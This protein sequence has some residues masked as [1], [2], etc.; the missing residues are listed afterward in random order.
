M[1]AMADPSAVGN[2]LALEIDKLGILAMLSPKA[3]CNNSFDTKERKK[4]MV[5]DRRPW[6]RTAR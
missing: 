2:S 1:L 3:L 4:N 5:S 6:L